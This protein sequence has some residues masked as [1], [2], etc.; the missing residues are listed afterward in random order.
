MVRELINSGMFGTKRV[1]GLGP[2]LYPVGEAAIDRSLAAGTES[3]ARSR[4]R[5]VELFHG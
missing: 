1:D 4:K 2:I 3:W 5:A